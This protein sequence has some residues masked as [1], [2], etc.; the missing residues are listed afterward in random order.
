MDIHYEW[1]SQELVSLNCW[2]GCNVAGLYHRT[3]GGKMLS[4]SYTRRE[5][6]IYSPG[7][8]GAP[9]TPVSSLSAHTLLAVPLISI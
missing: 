5:Y 8:Y 6:F 9:Y 2:S 4:Q 7:V 3:R 1:H